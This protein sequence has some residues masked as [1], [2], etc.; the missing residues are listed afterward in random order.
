M[1]TTRIACAKVLCLTIPLVALA[2]PGPP[3]GVLGAIGREHQSN[4]FQ[5]VPTIVLSSTRDFPASNLYASEI[6]LLDRDGTNPRR[7]TNNIASD[8]FPALSPDGKKI[9][10]ESNR[11]HL[12]TGEPRNVADLFVMDTDGGGQSPLTRGNSP[13]WSPDG[14]YIVFHASASYYASGGVVTGVPIK[15]DPGAATTDSDIFVANVDDLLNGVAAPW[16]LTSNPDAIDEDADWSPDGGNIAFTSHPA[17]DDS[18]NSS[19]AEIYLISADGS[20]A[21]RPLTN[22]DYEERAPAWSP[23]G[24]M[25]AHMCR[26]GPLNPTTGT[27]GFEICLLELGGLG[28]FRLTNNTVLDASPSWSPDGRKIV[29]HRGPQ[30]LQVWVIDLADLTCDAQTGMC[31][32][33]NP[34]LDTPAYS[35]AMPL[36]STPGMNVF[37][38]WSLLRVPKLGF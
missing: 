20:A 37:P 24:R 18:T 2:L 36:T 9:V 13:S 14:K 34:A 31:V 19:R 27:R 35:C 29:L 8:F 10:F 6:Y 11:Y 30:P 23:D 4:D 22:N 25:I 21:A 3:D 26:V 1:K 15:P 5:Y 17:N 32:C 12:G 38:K 16:N 28:I 7:L 33:S